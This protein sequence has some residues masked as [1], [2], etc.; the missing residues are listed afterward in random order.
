MTI[1]TEW[2]SYCIVTDTA[3]MFRGGVGQGLAFQGGEDRT[4]AGE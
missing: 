4:L 2:C 3:A 1:G